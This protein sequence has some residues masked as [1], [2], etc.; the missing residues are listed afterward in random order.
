MNNAMISLPSILSLAHLLGLA[1]GVGAATAKLTLL[2]RCH[3]D[4]A[5]V[6]VYVK[7]AKPITRQIVLSIIL[8]TLSGIGWPCWICHQA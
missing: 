1:L 4:H 7:V 8:L 2:L 5:L 3:A 6:P